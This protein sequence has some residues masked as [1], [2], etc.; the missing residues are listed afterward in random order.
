MCYRKC[1]WISKW[2][3]AYLQLLE[4]KRL[5]PARLHE[6]S[7]SEAIESAQNM[8]D[9]APG[10]DSGVCNYARDHRSPRY[11]GERSGKLE[12]LYEMIGLCLSCVR[13][14]ISATAE[15]NHNNV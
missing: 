5:W 1:G 6:I 14:G 12:H 15:C 7:L 11:R 8:P 3:Y 9:P 4:E 10:E 2:T 13:G